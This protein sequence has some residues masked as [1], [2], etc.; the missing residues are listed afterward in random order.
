[1]AANTESQTADLCV[2]IP[3]RDRRELLLRAL[4]SVAAQTLA[5]RQLIVVDNGSTDGS[6]DAAREWAARH[7]S[8]PTAITVIV[9]PTPG[10]PAARN[11]G[12]KRARTAWVAFFDSD[13]TMRPGFVAG[14]A[15][16]AAAA[17][18]ADII[19]WKALL[20]GCDGATRQLRFERRRLMFNHIHHG[21]L[22]TQRF[23][24]RRAL[25]LAAGGWR[26]L[27]IWNDWELGLRL[28]LTGP[29]AVSRGEVLVDIHAQRESITGTDFTSRADALRTAIEAALEE[30]PRGSRI[31][32]NVLFRYAVVAGHLAAEGAAE[33][34]AR[35]MAHA[36]AD[37]D[38]RGRVRLLMRLAYRWT[39]AGRR[40]APDIFATWI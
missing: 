29:H 34:A 18:Q 23:A 39:A 21:L 8:L 30:L 33:R 22:A 7:A 2:I 16:S 3:V 20:H 4:D 12:L 36:L 11:A 19:F 24:A 17:P 6:A 26:D 37:A 28:L 40:G 32:R 13:D 5:P 31:R 27:P 10:A 35:I 9:E 25:L 38:A 14:I 1:M 15:E